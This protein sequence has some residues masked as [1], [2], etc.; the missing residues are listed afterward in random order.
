MYFLFYNSDLLKSFNIR[1]YKVINFCKKIQS[2]YRRSNPYHNSAHATDVVQT[3]HYYMTK[4]G[5]IQTL[6]LGNLEKAALLLGAMVHDVDHPG[7]NNTYLI[8]TNNELAISYNDKSVLENHH[9]SFTF[10]ILQDQEFNILENFT[11]T[12]YKQMRKMMI[13]IVLCTDLATHFYELGNFKGRVLTLS[14]TNFALIPEEDK[15][16]IMSNAVHFADISNQTKQWDICFKWTEYLYDEFFAQGDDERQ[17][18]IPLG[19][20]NDRYKTNI[21]TAQVS[22]I[23]KFI[24]PSFETYALLLPKA[25][26]LC[27][28][29]EKNKKAWL[30]LVE[31]YEK[32]LKELN[33]N[34]KNKEIQMQ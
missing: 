4:L 12:E 2:C 13:N 11:P 30:D 18:N 33:D 22:F 7:K 20:L 14:E 31:H 10:K 16:C 3:I 19:F 27:E 26:I 15:L 1:T 24:V 6:K 9:I 17:Q 29:V 25:S 28:I 32:K 23:E 8:T 5:L 34:D 21:G